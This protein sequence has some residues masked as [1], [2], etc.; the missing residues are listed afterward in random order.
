MKKKIIFLILIISGILFIIDTIK[1]NY[2]IYRINN[3]IESIA[4]K[5]KVYK[6]KD[7]TPR[8]EYV[9]LKTKNN[10][11]L[12]NLFEKSFLPKIIPIKEKIFIINKIYSIKN[13]ELK[14]SATK[15]NIKLSFKNL[16]DVFVLDDK[17]FK[18]YEPLDRVVHYKV[19]HY[20]QLE[21]FLPK[22][23]NFDN[24]IININSDEDYF[25][26]NYVKINNN[27]EVV[28]E[29][30]I[31]KNVMLDFKNKIFS[32]EEYSRENEKA[33]IKRYD[34]TEKKKT[35]HIPIN[36]EI[37]YQNSHSNIIKKEYLYYENGDNR[38]ATY[39]EFGTLINF[40]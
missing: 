4:I 25:I 32:S 13:N 37:I 15:E 26:G 17:L 28:S 38:I 33:T 16:D 20:I 21:N 9:I 6:I 12:S 19:N 18:E 10:Y 8:K 11:E 2:N 27:F 29:F 5:K 1:Q 34:F 40:K 39:N 30:G 31:F 36:E 14:I 24:L 22:K 35:S 3:F 23:E 7:D